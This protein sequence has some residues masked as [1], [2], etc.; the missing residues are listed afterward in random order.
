MNKKSNILKISTTSYFLIL[1]GLLS[2]GQKI[3]ESIYKKEFKTVGKNEYTRKIISLSSTKPI[4]D[5]NDYQGGPIN[6][7]SSIYQFDNQ[8]LSQIFPTNYAIHKNE[9]L[10][11]YFSQKE[12]KCPTLFSLLNYYQSTIDL[13]LQKHQ[14]PKEIHLLPAVCSAFNPY[15]S[16]GIGGEG[17]WHLNYPQA[18]KYGLKV[19]GLVDERRDFKKST[20]AA[21]RYLKDLYQMYNNW[22]LTL[23]AYSSGVT[24]VNKYL[25]RYQASSYREIDKYLP[26]ETKD[27][28]QA[29]VAMNYIHSYDDYGTVQLTPIITSDTLIIDQKLHFQALNDILKISLDELSFLNPTVNREIFQ[30]NSTVF[31]PSHTKQKFIEQQDSI[32]FYQD[33]IL[34]KPKVITQDI[35]I[36]KNGAPFTYRVKSGDVLGLIADRHGVKVAQIQ[37]W[38]NLNSTRINIGQKLTLYGNNPNVNKSSKDKKKATTVKKKGTLKKKLPATTD[39]YTIYTV[40]SGESLWLIAKKFSGVSA[41]NIMDFNGIDNNL[42]VGQVLKIPI[43]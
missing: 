14:L 42:N 6:V 15:S 23:A 29:F 24:T 38:N 2:Y 22:E 21:T 37:D 40:K 9:Y 10:V 39:K 35:V 27:L 33:S 13:Y 31:L 11:F 4:K 41:Q 16:N 12:A 19:N 5:W 34:L 20:M 36:P 30:K 18:I 17:F 3:P 8:S 26:I 1:I 25:N 7:D 43:Y 32:Y 28:V